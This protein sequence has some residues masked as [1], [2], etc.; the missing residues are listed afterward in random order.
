ML[1]RVIDFLKL[2]LNV[3]RGQW[4]HLGYGTT[5]LLH[6]RGVHQ[7][8]NSF[9]HAMLESQLSVIVCIAY[10]IHILSGAHE[11][12]MSILSDSLVNP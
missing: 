11:T 1:L 12:L 7:Y 6:S 9:D 10:A 2:V 4:I 8:T 5:V 3:D